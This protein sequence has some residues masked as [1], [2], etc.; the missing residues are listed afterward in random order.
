MLTIKTIAAV[1]LILI[2]CSLQAADKASH[3]IVIVWDGMRPDFVTE[4]TAPTLWKMAREGA[5]FANHHP[6]Y[7]SST[8][9]NGTA[10][11]TGCYP[12]ISGIVA[13]F[14]YRP[15]INLTNSVAT[16]G[17][18]TIRK[19]DKLT[20][21]G[22]IQVA[23]VAE[24]LH[25]A[26][27]WTVIAGSKPVAQLQDRF[28]RPGDSSNTVVFEGKSI[29]AAISSNL[30]GLFGAFP[31]GTPTK[32]NRDI[33]TTSALVGPLWEKG[34]PDYSLLWLGEPDGAQHNTAPGSSLALKAIRN[35]D[36]MLARVLAE[37]EKRH[38]RDKTDV[39]VVSDHGFSTA[40]ES[41]DVVKL[42]KKNGFAAFRHFPSSGPS[43]GDIL[44]IGGPSL[45]IY[46]TGH[47]Q[48]LIERVAHFLQSQPFCGVVF[49]KNPVEG[50]FP[51]DA[52]KINSA[53]APDI[54]VSLRWSAQA[55]KYNIPG[56]VGYDS[57]TK[58]SGNGTHGTLSRYDMHNICFASGPDFQPG[59][60]D[61][62]ATGNVDIAP[63]VLWIL[64]VEP[65]QPL[66]GR[67]LGEAMTGDAPKVSSVDPSHIEAS[68]KGDGFTWKQY[69]NYTKV[70]GTIYLDEANGEQIR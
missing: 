19:G 68:Y 50:A 42:L 31:T 25:A 30:A 14:E 13:N 47:D 65:K 49:T 56:R 60:V 58:S 37:L 67:V 32:T 39:I 20:G 64:G 53:D 69:L 36:D 24:T 38:L 16:E 70:N 63:T 44:V 43:S 26:G 33:W 8:E 35:S 48:G 61:T 21:N 27:R 7:V 41:V 57:V 55:N 1:L 4:A 62:V 17:F 52:A 45:L 51:L 12:Q 54:M 6:V 59:F 18:A 66:S 22:Y 2:A 5:T 9:V 28:E 15:A 11:A 46:V 34:V 23:T 10:I 29:P 40:L 3:V